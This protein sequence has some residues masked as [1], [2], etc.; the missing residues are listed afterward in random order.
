LKMPE[1]IRGPV[2]LTSCRID[3]RKGLELVVLAAP[4]VLQKMPE[5]IFVIRG[6]IEDPR[7]SDE[8]HRLIRD[9][10][11]ED[12]VLLS[13]ERCTYQDLPG[14]LSSAQVFVHPSLDESLGLAVAEALACGI[15]V[16]ATRVGGIP[17]LVQDMVN[18]LLVEPDPSCVSNAI[19]RILTDKVLYNHLREG[20][21][22]FSER[23]RQPNDSDF[24]RVFET[25]IRQLL[26]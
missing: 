25:I 5:A 15:P 2:I 18:G 8:L 3:R 10:G 14:I 26:T 19:L 23:I 11:L 20:A 22:R 16:I 24:G 1:G 6:P 9:Q 21:N 17:E 4:N 12:R 13:G 7:Y